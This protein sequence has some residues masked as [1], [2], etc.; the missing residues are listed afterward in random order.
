MVAKWGGVM[1]SKILDIV[2]F[3][4]GVVGFDDYSWVVV[5]VLEFGVGYKR[6]RWGWLSGG[7][8]LWLSGCVG[9]A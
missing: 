8:W 2:V 6:L 4:S 1:F 9:Y 3:D 7:A 5:K